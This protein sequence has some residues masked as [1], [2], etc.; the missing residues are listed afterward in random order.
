M[1]LKREHK[2]W[3]STF[4]LGLY[5]FVALFSQNFHEHGSSDYF[6]KFNFKKVE[7]SVSKSDIQNDFDHC[8]SCHFLHEGKVFLGGNFSYEFHFIEDFQ[9]ENFSQDFSFYQTQLLH[10]YL[11]GPPNS[12][13]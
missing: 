2:T 7:K 11:R 12:L 13:V 1:K 10:F 9:Q 5:L 8:L 6:K 3:F 4:L